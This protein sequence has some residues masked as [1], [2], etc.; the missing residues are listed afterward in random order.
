MVAP[1]YIESW[2]FSLINR[3]YYGTTEISFAPIPVPIKSK[4]TD[5]GTAEMVAR[6]MSLSFVLHRKRLG[7]RDIR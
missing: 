6:S 1:S 2:Q 7:L 4:I 5:R 3:L